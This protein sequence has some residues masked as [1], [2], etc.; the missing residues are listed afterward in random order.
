MNDLVSLY[1]QGP[2]A[3]YLG[4]Q[5]QQQ[6][7]AG[8]RI[9]QQ[10]QLQNLYQRRQTDPIDL[11]YKKALAEES[12]ARV[13]GMTETNRKNKLANDMEEQTFDQQR[14]ASLAKLAGEASEADLKNARA[15]IEVMMLHDDPKV[16]SQGQ[17]LFAT[18]KEL[19]LERQKGTMQFND[20]EAEDARG[21]GYR[22]KEIAAQGQNA[23]NVKAI[24]PPA[25]PGSNKPM[26]MSQLEASLREKAMAGDET[27]MQALATLEEDKRV[28]AA[29]SAGVA[30]QF[31]RELTG[32]AKPTEDNSSTGKV[33]PKEAAKPTSYEKGKTYTG[34]TGTY[35]YIGGDPADKNSWKKVK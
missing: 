22:M 7:Q 2:L 9:K 27:A 8:E 18:F 24:A 33:K 3:G 25:K 19:E 35:E 10:E 21:H 14:R 16:R 12:R 4:A 23:A 30:D 20:K 1:G 26:T 32:T 28:R 31:K 34:R 17:H 15:Q 11:D 5:Q 13:G 29:A 6:A